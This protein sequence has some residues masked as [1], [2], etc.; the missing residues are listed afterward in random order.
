VGRGRGAGPSE[1]AHER[2]RESEKESEK[3]EMRERRTERKKVGRASERESEF[4]RWGEGEGVES[5]KQRE[6]T[7][8]EMSV[9]ANEHVYIHA[10]IQHTC[11]VHSN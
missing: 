4:E 6:C 11:G 1:R 7:Y 3:E 5:V 9:S 10:Y 8:T 2:D